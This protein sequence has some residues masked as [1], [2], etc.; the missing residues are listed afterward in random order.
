MKERKTQRFVPYDLT[1]EWFDKVCLLNPNSPSFTSELIS[2]KEEKSSHLFSLH[3]F[4]FYLKICYNINYTNF[5]TRN[6]NFFVS[7]L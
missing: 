6:C 3:K 2:E 4:D 1:P 5:N 7:K